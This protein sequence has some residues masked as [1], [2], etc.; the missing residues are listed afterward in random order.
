MII[1]LDLFENLISSD[2]TE[3]QSVYQILY[4]INHLT[5]LLDAAETGVDTTSLREWL[6]SIGSKI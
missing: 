1:N 5:K 3:K 2:S 6:L 4:H